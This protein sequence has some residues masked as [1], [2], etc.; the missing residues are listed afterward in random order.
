MNE[1]DEA[2]FLRWLVE[3]NGYAAPVALP[4]AR[5]ACLDIRPYNT[6]IIT[7]RI[8]DRFGIDDAW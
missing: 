6:R 8:G 5:Y 4:G 7:A 1:N 2:D 3:A